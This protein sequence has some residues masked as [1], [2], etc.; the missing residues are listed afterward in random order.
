MIWLAIFLIGTV[1]YY[2]VSDI[3]L[4]KKGLNSIPRASIYRS[5]LTTQWLLVFGLLLLWWLL[6]FRFED[7]FYYN[8]EVAAGIVFE[9]KEMFLGFLVGA[10]LVVVILPFLMKKGRN[11][12]AFEKIDFM[13]PK[14]IG[15]R[16]T[17]FFIAVTAGVC[18]E[19]IFRGATTYLLLNIGVELPI[20]AIGVIGAVLFGLAH[21]YQGLS[22]IVTTG[23]IGYAMFNLYVQTGSLLVPML[24]HFLIDVKFVFM[25]DWRKKAGVLHGEIAKS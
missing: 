3:Q 10:I 2:I 12:E 16:V 22:G 19:I 18:E 14:T 11:I 5:L 9:N 24:L 21:W 1:T 15:Q 7:L 17:F 25:P 20:W 6:D 4:M 13:L 8:G 23:L